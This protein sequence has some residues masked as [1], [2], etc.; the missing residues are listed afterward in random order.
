MRH[1]L[2]HPITGIL[3]YIFTIVVTQCSVTSIAESFAG[4]RIVLY[5]LWLV[6]SMVVFMVGI[7]TS[8]YL[9]G[10]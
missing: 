10:S 9:M 1:L 4:E 2:L 5:A 8:I 3:L 6:S 7:C